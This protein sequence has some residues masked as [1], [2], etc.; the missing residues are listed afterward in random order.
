M[1]E[2][3]DDDDDCARWDEG[4]GSDEDDHASASAPALTVPTLTRRG[5]VA[6]LATLFGAIGVVKAAAPVY[7]P[8][9]YTWAGVDWGVGKSWTAYSGVGQTIRV[10]MPQRFVIRDASCFSAQPLTG[11]DVDAWSPRLDGQPSSQRA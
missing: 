3:D 4:D 10:R 11:V 9:T 2:P 7:A 5:F 6:R 1:R 8:L